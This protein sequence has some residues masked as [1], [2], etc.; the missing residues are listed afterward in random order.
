MLMIGILQVDRDMLNVWAIQFIVD[1][2]CEPRGC[3]GICGRGYRYGE[4]VGCAEQ[5]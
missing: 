2:V 4:T 1:K 5:V 3:W